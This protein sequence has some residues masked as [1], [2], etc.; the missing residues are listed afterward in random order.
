MGDSKKVSDE[1]ASKSAN[2]HDAKVAEK[3]KDYATASVLYIKVDDMKSVRRIA[4]RAVKQ[5]GTTSCIG[6]A[7]DKF[8]RMDIN[9]KESKDYFPYLKQL[10]DME[11]KATKH[12]AIMLREDY[13]DALSYPARWPHYQK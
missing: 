7:L 6:Y 5:Y 8:S 10:A 4:Q 1:M 3:D 9:S 2:L 12:L 11:I 13:S